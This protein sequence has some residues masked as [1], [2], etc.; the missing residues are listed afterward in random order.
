MTKKV[1]IIQPYVP[2]YR[3]AF[4]ENL[5]ASLD[6]MGV[7][8]VVT[9]GVPKGAQAKR[10]DAAQPDWL[11]RKEQKNLRIKGRSISLGYGRKPWLNADA[12]ILGLEGSS[13]PV[14]QALREAR[15]TNLRVGLW[16]HV[17]PYV[18]PGNPLDLWLEKR[19]MQMADHIFAYM[20]G[21][22]EYAVNHGISPEKIT[23]VMNTVDTSA[24]VDA[25]ATTT[26]IDIESFAG[27]VQFDPSRAV[28][29][30]GGLDGSK[31]ID[32]LAET[33]EELWVR[34]SSI[35]LLVAGQGEEEHFLNESYARGQARPLGY[36]D[37]NKKALALKSTR[38]ICMPGR[39]GLVAVDALVAKRP[40]ITTNWKFHAPEIE[41]LTEGSARITAEDDPKAYAESILRC[42]ENHPEPHESDYPR[43]DTMVDNFAQGIVQMLS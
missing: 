36:V 3:V 20:P 7:E 32:F 13:L 23:T 6:A 26:E 34:D 42:I 37:T 41:Y 25:L 1:I 19:Q 9:A 11:E 33:L 22:S 21:G 24:L 29:F 4:F 10:G 16:G 18:A 27:T 17:R 8:C 30:L 15:S 40:I 43:L 12:V 14:Y 5:I 39:V 38:A 31:R 35:K 28:C 2:A